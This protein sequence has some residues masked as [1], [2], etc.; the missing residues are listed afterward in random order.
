MSRVAYAALGKRG[1]FSRDTRYTAPPA[2]AVP[3]APT[4]D[5][6]EQA[7]RA[8]YEDGQISTRAECEAQLQA[9]RAARSAIETAFARFD[10]ESGRHLRERLLHGA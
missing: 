3:A 2:D 4:E 8:G 1:S 9:E 10:A 6:A 5:A 7:Y